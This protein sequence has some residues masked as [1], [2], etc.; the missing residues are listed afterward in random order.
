MNTTVIPHPPYSPNFATC[1][2]FL[3]PKI[4]LKLRGRRFD[5]IEDIQT[6]SQIAMKTLTRNDFQKCFLSWKYCWNR[7]INA[8]GDYLEGEGEE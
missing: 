2:F 6:E 7:Y 5:S 1:D 8:K 3:F 4:T